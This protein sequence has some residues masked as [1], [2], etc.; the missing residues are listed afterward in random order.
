M[1]I[2]DLLHNF[3][4]SQCPLYTPSCLGAEETQDKTPGREVRQVGEMAFLSFQLDHVACKILGPRLG[5]EPVAPA[6][7]DQSLSHWTTREV[8]RWSF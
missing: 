3:K 7:G 5:I 6:V 8:L 2:L 1:N 4:V